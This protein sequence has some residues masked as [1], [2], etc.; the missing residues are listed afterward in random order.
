VKV[1]HPPSLEGAHV[2][3]RPLT[4]DDYPFLRLIETG[5]ALGARWRFRGTTPSP[6]EWERQTSASVLAQFM[7]IA[8]ESMEAL[9]LVTAYEANFQDG[10][11]SL[12]AAKLDPDDRSPLMMFGVAHFIEYVFTCWNLRKLYVE[13]PEYNYA[14]FATGEDRYFTVE[15]R[16]REHSY[17]DG[18]LWDRLI[19]AIHRDRWSARSERL[20]QVQAVP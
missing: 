15:G 3:L 7:V 14:Q 10:Y 5:Q 12:A 9:G 2:V 18:Q 8:K 11:A 16:L 6:Q 1:F 19:L 13:V 20:L 17:Y 4:P